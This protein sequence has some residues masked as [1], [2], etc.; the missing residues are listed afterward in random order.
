MMGNLSRV[1]RCAIVVIVID[2]NPLRI[3]ETLDLNT[4]GK[5]YLVGSINEL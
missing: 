5:I 4:K 1:A 3:P 2:R